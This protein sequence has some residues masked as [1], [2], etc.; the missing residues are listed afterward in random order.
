MNQVSSKILIA[1]DIGKVFYEPI[2]HCVLQSNS[3]DVH[4]GELISIYGKSGSGKST[5]LYI[6]AT[7]DTKFEGRLTIDSID[8]K[9]QTSS[10]LSSFRNTNIGFV[11]QSHYLLQEFNVLQNVMLPALKT[12]ANRSEIENK[13]TELLKELGLASN[14]NYPVY[15]LSGGE[16]QRVS[17]ARCLIRN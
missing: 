11:Y 2:Q 10:Y 16:Q 8:I 1:Q 7:L 13:A 12:S 3:F 4:K 5:L 15:K 17:I 6:L 14:V 9:K